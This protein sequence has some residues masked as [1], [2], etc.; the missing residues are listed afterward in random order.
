[1]FAFISSMLI[2]LSF[3]Y[4]SLSIQFKYPHTQ[5]YQNALDQ[6]EEA[7]R[8]KGTF[9]RKNKELTEKMNHTYEEALHAKQ[10]LKGSQ[11]EIV[12]LKLELEQR[13]DMLRTERQRGGQWESIAAQHA[14]E[15][16]LLEKTKRVREHELH[17]IRSIIPKREGEVARAKKTLS[18]MNKVLEAEA[19]QRKIRED[20]TN[21]MKTK[22]IWLEGTLKKEMERNDKLQRGLA[23]VA[24]QLNTLVCAQARPEARKTL[25][26]KAWVEE[27]S[28]LHELVAPLI[29]TNNTLDD[30][31]LDLAKQQQDTH[32]KQVCGIMYLF[33]LI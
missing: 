18:E 5:D 21:K 15:V 7:K 33:E 9:E 25:D 12:K 14:E 13:D 17:D 20:N 24:Q 32:D 22:K 1:M 3:F 28:R 27:L 10:A 11:E 8:Q 26:V 31:D 6:L 4:L 16:K 29:A 23:R 19:E 2:A 30:K